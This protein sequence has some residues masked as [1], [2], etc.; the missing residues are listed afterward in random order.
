MASAVGDLSTPGFEAGEPTDIFKK[1]PENTSLTGF[2]DLKVS[3]LNTYNTR[4]QTIDFEFASCSPT[5]N[6]MG[7]FT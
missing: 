7:V 5:G 1:I 6:E 4:T 2:Y 3:P